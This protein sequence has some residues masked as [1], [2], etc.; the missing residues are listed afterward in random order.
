[1]LANKHYTSNQKWV[2]H[3]FL[4]QCNAMQFFVLNVC[5]T[6]YTVDYD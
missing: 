6:I 2:H 1:M 3:L 5:Y 4:M